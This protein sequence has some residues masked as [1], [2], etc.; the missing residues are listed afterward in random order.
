MSLGAAGG[1]ASLWLPSQ[2]RRS[3]AGERSPARKKPAS[4]CALL[5]A[6]KQV[7][8]K[9]FHLPGHSRSGEHGLRLMARSLTQNAVEVVLGGYTPDPF[10]ERGH[11]G[12]KP[13]AHPVTYDVAGSAGIECHDS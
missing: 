9:L 12:C 4:L 7:V 6:G 3:R 5:H 1:G 10:H 11:V 13:A 2:V 8:V